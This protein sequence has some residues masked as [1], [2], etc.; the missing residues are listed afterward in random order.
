[1]RFSTSAAMLITGVLA[2]HAALAQQA[3]DPF[4]ALMKRAQKHASTHGDKFTPALSPDD[5]L[6]FGPNPSISVKPST[7]P[8]SK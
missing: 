1:M 6:L 4:L 2:T 7:P 5:S 3:N 8:A